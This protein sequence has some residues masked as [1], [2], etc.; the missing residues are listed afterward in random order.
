MGFYERSCMMLGEK[1]VNKF[2][3]FV[4]VFWS[5]SSFASKSI[6]VIP[7]DKHT[8]E[9]HNLLVLWNFIEPIRKLQHLL[10]VGV[11]KLL[12][13]I[14]LNGSYW[15]ATWNIFYV[16][17]AQTEIQIFLDFCILRLTILFRMKHSIS[18]TDV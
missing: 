4:S 16:T 5:H 7:D 10:T 11:G 18:E 14:W 12:I 8:L 1:H 17:M 3:G 13:I 2:F 6:V 15:K 9:V